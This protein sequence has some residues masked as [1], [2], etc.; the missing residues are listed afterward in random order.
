MKQANYYLIIDSIR[1]GNIEPIL[2]KYNY[3]Y[4]S[5]YSGTEWASQITLSPLW[6][7]VTPDCYI[8]EKWNH[9]ETWGNSG[10]IYQYVDTPHQ[11]VIEQFKNNITTY[12]DDGKLY[13]VRYYSPKALYKALSKLT[14]DIITHFTCYANRIYISKNASNKINKNLI[15]KIDITN[16]NTRNCFSPEMIKELMF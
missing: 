2:E 11:E 15:F 12:S 13:L 4:G 5:L 6:I 3:E 7:K 8:W 10:I 14:E 16:S 9:N 1:I